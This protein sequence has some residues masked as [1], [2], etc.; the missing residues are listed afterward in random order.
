MVLQQ[1]VVVITGASS[2]FGELIARRC[3][4]GGARVV[5]AA[6]SVAKLEQLAQELGG[7][8]RALVV[9]V[10]VGS[11]ADVQTLVDT[12]LERF[13]GADVLVNNAGYGV[14]NPIADAPLEELHAMM[15]VNVYGALRCTRAFLP[16]MLA[17]RSGQVVMMA[18]IA[19]HVAT[20]NM[21]YYGATKHALV[22]LTRVLA[23]ELAGTGVR[24]A[25]ICP[26]VAQTG[27]QER[28]GRNKF[29][30]ITRLSACTP[31]QVANATLRVIAR[32]THGEV[33]I[34]WYGRLLALASQPFPSLT[35]A[36]MQLIR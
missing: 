30:R 14:F 28:A 16:H 7:P 13:G 1:K 24:C 21:G 17:R 12:T 23:V 20:L 4:A 15:D 32:Q 3:A 2:G 35:R 25:L 22:G 8:S 31:E 5:L 9:R 29:A 18:S 36:I 26:G 11:D 19:G 10:D 34:P 6:R 33:F 27:F